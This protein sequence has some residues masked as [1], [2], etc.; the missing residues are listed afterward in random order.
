MKKLHFFL[1]YSKHLI[2]DAVY[3][4]IKYHI[5]NFY[6]I[7]SLGIPGLTKYAGWTSPVVFFCLVLMNFQTWKM[8]IAGSN[9]S[10]FSL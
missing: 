9:K 4:K 10:Y 1:I 5:W 3:L 6:K 2:L 8:N 7:L